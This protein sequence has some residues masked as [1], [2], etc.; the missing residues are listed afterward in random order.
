MRIALLSDRIPPEGMGG[1]ENLAWGLA[2]GLR[3]ASVDVHVIATTPG[4]AFDEIRDGVPTTHLHAGYPDRW[5]AWLSLWNPQTVFA[6]RRQLRRIKPDVVNAH[7]IH[8]YLSY[9]SLKVARDLGMPTVFCAYDCM[10]FA[11]GKLRHFARSDSAAIDLPGAYRLPRGYNLRHNRIRYNPIRNRVIRHYLRRYADIR[12]APSQ[13]LADAFAVNDLPPVE[14]AHNGVDPALWTRPAE[15]VIAVLRDR[16]DLRDK[17]IIL[18]AGRLSRDKGTIQLLRAMDRL[19][20]ELPEMR[21]LALTARDLEAQIPADFRHLR[22]L[23]RSAGWLNGDELRAAF[24][25]SHVVATPSIAFDTFP[26]VNLEAM[27]CAKPVVTTIFGG[28]GEAVVD[29]ETGFVVNPLDTVTF[30]DRLGRLLRDDS[31][32]QDMGSRG[33]QRLLRHFTLQRHVN[34]MLDIY[35]RAMERTE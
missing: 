12:T 23:I 16:L 6:L 35:R 7:N 28:A 33:R 1:A 18:F 26:T 22:P 17:R 15:K 5:R 14:V 20:D 19:K 2:L 34:Q 30:A 10:P 9:H 31:L 11:Y 29:G 24:H 4:P 32:R 21:L 25:L 13:A 27:A 3:A 8:F